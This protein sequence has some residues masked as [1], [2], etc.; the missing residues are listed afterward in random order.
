VLALAHE[1]F[2][3]HG[4]AHVAGAVDEF[5][6]GGGGLVVVAVCGL[7]AEDAGVAAWAGEVAVAEGGEEGWEVF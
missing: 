1:G 4:E 7:D 5:E 2:G 6:D 3:R